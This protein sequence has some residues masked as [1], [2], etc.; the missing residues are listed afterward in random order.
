MA[1]SLRIHPSDNVA[2]TLEALAPGQQLAA[3]IVAREAIPPGHKLALAAI[4]AGG[5]AIKYGWPIGRAT[6]DIPPGAWVHTHNLRTKLSGVIE[7]QYVAPASQLPRQGG[8][9]A[10]GAP[11]LEVPLFPGFRRADGRVGIRNELWILPTVGCV[12]QLAQ[13]LAALAGERFAGGAIDG[14]YAFPHP[15]GCSQLG[16]D[17]ANTQRAL[18]ALLRHPNAGGV[19]L[20]GLGCESNFLERQ[21][22]FCGEI[23]PRRVKCLKTQEAGDEL[24]DGLRLLEQLAAYAGGF[25]RE[26]CPAS[27]LVVGMK[28]G[29]S[30]GFSGITANPLVGRITDALTDWGGTV[31]LTEVPEMFGGEQ[32]LMSRARDRATF[33]GIVALI[34][35]FKRYFLDH[36]QPIYE[37]PTPGNRDGGLTTLEEKS[38]GC[39]Q[40]GGRATVTQVLGYGRPTAAPGLNLV[41]AP[42]NDG[43]STTALVLSGAVLLLFTTGRGTPMGTPAPVLKI[44]S[45]TPLARRKP[46]WIDF[47]AGR[48]LSESADTDA[49]AAELMDLV[50]RTAAGQYRTRNEANG[51]RDIAIFKTGVT[52]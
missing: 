17:L 22:Q 50:L 30:D 28:C 49:L 24:A 51:L 42:G 14:V 20:L 13:R 6:A 26:P 41:N 48:L 29:G 32:V 37:N 12:A 36:N 1:A 46:N 23:D 40:K 52:V 4:P 19:L 44:A 25:R 11:A 18:A 15:Y 27:G 10:S 3:G 33:D 9:A 47:D 16:D 5:D 2:V 38:L 35:G 45:N 34:D 31:L 21:L 43:V 39:I 7:Y 8:A